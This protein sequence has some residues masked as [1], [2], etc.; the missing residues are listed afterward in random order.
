MFEVS[1]SVIEIPGP[2]FTAQKDLLAVISTLSSYF[3]QET[4]FIV[5]LFW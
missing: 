5:T 3:L 1:R 2:V 4:Y